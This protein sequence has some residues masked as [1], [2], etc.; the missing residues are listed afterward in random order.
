MPDPDTKVTSGFNWKQPGEIP[1]SVARE[2]QKV[3]V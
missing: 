2:K 1:D 3:C